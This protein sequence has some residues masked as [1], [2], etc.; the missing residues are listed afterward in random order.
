[1][2]LLSTRRTYGSS[3]FRRDLTAGLLLSAL[4]APARMGYV[5]PAG[6]RSDDV[7]VCK[8]PVV[9]AGDDQ[10]RRGPVS[11]REGDDT[12]GP[13]GVHDVDVVGTQ[14]CIEGPQ[15]DQVLVEAEHP[16]SGSGPFSEEV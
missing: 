6:F 2:P 9:E 15:P 8:G 12:G 3:S 1:M 4:L 11:P 5:E 7:A 13:V 14:G 16:R 10:Q